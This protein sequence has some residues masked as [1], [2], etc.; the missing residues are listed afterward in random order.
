MEYDP[1]TAA[2]L[3]ETVKSVP[4]KELK[5]MFAKRVEK[6]AEENIDDIAEFSKNIL[7]FELF[8]PQAAILKAYYNQNLDK[9]QTELLER[10]ASEGRTNWQP[11]RIYEELVL[12]CGMGSG[13]SEISVLIG[14]FELSKL[15]L[16]PD[17]A[18]HF[19]LGSGSELFV[20]LVAVNREQAYD[21]LFT[22]LKEKVVR[23]P[24][25]S[26]HY[27]MPKR[28]KQ[29]E[30]R[31]HRF[32]FP[33]KRLVIFTGTSSSGGMVGRNVACVVFDELPRYQAQGTERAADGKEVAKILLYDTL[34]KSVQRL[35][36]MGKSVSIG[37]PL[38]VDDPIM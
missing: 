13:K 18:K 3:I 21:T 20:V 30:S 16:M 27:Y 22:K 2:A 37:S 23:H 31:G 15:L 17:P 6:L 1:E 32:N 7:D 24:W 29:E 19:G 28:G 12:I 11:G 10:W 34:T 5:K 36:G 38:S 4:K 26:A 8:V 33:D 25:Y 35:K 9:E 14:T